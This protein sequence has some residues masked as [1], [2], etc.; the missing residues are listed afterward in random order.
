MN[1]SI[2]GPK[3]QI[4]SK[5]LSFPLEELSGQKKNTFWNKAETN[6]TQTQSHKQLTIVF[7]MSH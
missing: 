5:L 7:M 4:S 1:A 6:N 2:V 3:E